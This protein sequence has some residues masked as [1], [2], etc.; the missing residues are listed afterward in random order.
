MLQHGFDTRCQSEILEIGLNTSQDNN[1]IKNKYDFTR[2]STSEDHKDHNGRLNCNLR[3][4]RISK[5]H[6]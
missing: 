3:N 2:H 1:K 4:Q 5:C 6:Y